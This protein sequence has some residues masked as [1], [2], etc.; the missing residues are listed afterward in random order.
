MVYTGYKKVGDTVIIQ[1]SNSREELEKKGFEYIAS[2]K[3]DRQY[4]DTLFFREK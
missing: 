1:E 2:S 3:R 4:Y